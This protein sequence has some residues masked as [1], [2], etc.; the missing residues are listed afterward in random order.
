VAEWSDKIRA[1]RL[2]SVVKVQGYLGVLRDNGDRSFKVR[3]D[4]H[5]NDGV[6]TTAVQGIEGEELGL[7]ELTFT[8]LEFLDEPNRGLMRVQCEGRE[9]ASFVP[10]V[11]VDGPPERT[12]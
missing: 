7:V 2:G 5:W 8:V 11:A 4:A 12:T 1:L 3:A 10:Y 9:G 6:Y